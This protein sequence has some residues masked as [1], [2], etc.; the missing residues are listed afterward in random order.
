MQDIS[1]RIHSL[2]HNYMINKCS[3]SGR[4]TYIIIHTYTIHDYYDYDYDYYYLAFIHRNCHRINPPTND[5][6]IIINHVALGKFSFLILFYFAIQR[7]WLCKLPTCELS[8]LGWTCLCSK[9]NQGFKDSRLCCPISTKPR[10]HRYLTAKF[11]RDL[12]ASKSRYRDPSA[13]LT[14]ALSPPALLSL[15]HHHNNLSKIH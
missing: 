4:H 3:H 12:L 2:L 15:H 10:S 14:S 8:N 1:T 11:L 13:G 6:P 9:S 5:Y 7:R